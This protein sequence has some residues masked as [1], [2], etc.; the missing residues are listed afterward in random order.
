MLSIEN[1]ANSSMLMKPDFILCKVLDGNH[2]I[3]LGNFISLFMK[4]YC[5]IFKVSF[6]GYC[7][8][9]DTKTFLKALVMLWKMTDLE[10]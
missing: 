7:Y 3:S 10:I 1:F 4:A 2:F 5:I 6:P 9:V 8:T